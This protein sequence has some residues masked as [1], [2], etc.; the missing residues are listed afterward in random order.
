MTY[1]NV[2]NGRTI[3]PKNGMRNVSKALLTISGRAIQTMRKAKRGNK[4]VKTA[5]M[6]PMSFFL[7]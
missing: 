7:S 2:V 5:K 4:N 1:I 3:T 6:Q